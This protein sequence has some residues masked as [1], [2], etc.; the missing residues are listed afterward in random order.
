MGLYHYG[1]FYPWTSDMGS[2]TSDLIVCQTSMSYAVP[3]L[4]LPREVPY[5]LTMIDTSNNTLHFSHFRHFSHLAG[6]VCF[7]LVNK[8]IIKF[9]NITL[10]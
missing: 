7:L 1:G 9:E 6:C 5:P 3:V 10:Q 2:N 4:R 8:L